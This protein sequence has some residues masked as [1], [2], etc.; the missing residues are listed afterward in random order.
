MKRKP[1]TAKSPTIAIVTEAMIAMSEPVDRV[2]FVCSGMADCLAMRETEGDAT[3]LA[4]I[5]MGSQ[6]C[7]RHLGSKT[8]HH[9]HAQRYVCIFSHWPEPA[10]S[11]PL[12]VVGHP[13]VCHRSVSDSISQ[14]A[15]ILTG[16]L[17]LRIVGMNLKRRKDNNKSVVLCTSCVKQQK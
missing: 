2:L 7:V 5:P 10:T 17:P 12:E 15:Q 16:A 9:I 3:H 8:D 1:R 14:E 13:N 4:D 11:G 6:S